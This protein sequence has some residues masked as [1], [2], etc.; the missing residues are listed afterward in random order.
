MFQGNES[1]F[2]YNEIRISYLINPK[3]NLKFESGIISR[4]LED[5]ITTNISN[6]FFFAL[7]SDLF[8]R[9]YDY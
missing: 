6:F 2:R 3:T 1:K 7:K 8:N 4:K 9:Y 5:N